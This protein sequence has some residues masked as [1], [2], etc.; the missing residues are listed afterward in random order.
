MNDSFAGQPTRNKSGPRLSGADLTSSFLAQGASI[1]GSVLILRLAG[2]EYGAEGLGDY[3][4]ARRIFSLAQPV[5]L[6]GLH[7]ALPK[8]V[9]ESSGDERSWLKAS[10]LVLLPWAVFLSLPLLLFPRTVSSLLFGR[11]NMQALC[12]PLAAMLVGSTCQGLLYAY[13]RGRM[14]FIWASAVMGFNL[15]IV[16][17][18]AFFATATI[19]GNLFFVATLWGLNALP[20]AFMQTK[21]SAA[22]HHVRDLFSYGLPRTAADLSQI[23]L[24]SV[25]LLAAN[26][27][28]SAEGSRVAA[29]SLALVSNLAFMF[30]PLSAMLLPVTARAVADK[31]GGS[32]TRLMNM[33][34]SLTVLVSV[35]LTTVMLI[36]GE[37]ILEWYLVSLP[38]GLTKAV[39]FAVP[40]IIPLSIYFTLRGSID[41]ASDRPYNLRNLIIATG[42]TTALCIYYAIVGLSV[43]NMML[44]FVI[45]SL[46][47]GFLSWMTTRHI[48]GLQTTNV[49]PSPE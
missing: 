17:V 45:G 42:V 44:A 33:L 21:V 35:L 46:C 18:V 40:G 37:L 10:L 12:L 36:F 2:T 38:A 9:A 11:D 5:F 41:G 16:P 14:R 26:H 8:R 49:A 31:Q 43:V 25:P 6:L 47:L 24:F 34:A 32:L 4:L 7:I 48:S 23:A 22:T 19:E 20:L 3:A 29:L 1:I 39:K 28:L 30:A 15:G 27:A 13:L